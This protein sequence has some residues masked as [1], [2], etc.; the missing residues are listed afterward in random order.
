MTNLGKYDILGIK[1]AT[2][3]YEYVIEQILDSTKKMQRL[4]IAPVASHP[5]VEAYFNKT[6]QGLL[7]RFDL[8][9]PDSQYVRWAINF[10]YDIKL[11]DRVYGP[12]L[13]IRLCKEV[14]RRKIKIFLYGNNINKLRTVLK[15]L[16][17]KLLVFGID[18]KGEA[19]TNKEINE[20]SSR[21]KKS[22]CKLLF[23][24]LSS[25][26]QHKIVNSLQDFNYPVIAVGAAFDFVSGVKAQAPRWMQKIGLEWF[27]RFI[28]EPRRL[29]RRYLICGPLF[30]F[31]VIWQKGSFLTPFKMRS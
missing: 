29:G 1:M 11:T 9:V 31:L 4:T 24:G 27:F 17:P 8:I 6:F 25:P 12:E 22:N 16:F 20:L 21:L 10:L 2:C 13:F 30:I 28:N 7:N 19:V 5:I 15:K 3:N 14:E 23:I 26:L 18:L